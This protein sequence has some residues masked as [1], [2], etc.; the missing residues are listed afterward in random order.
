[1]IS[2]S[3]WL[4]WSR[5]NCMIYHVSLVGSRLCT[6]K[7]C[8]TLHNGSPRCGSVVFSD[9]QA[10]CVQRIA[11][12]GTLFRSSCSVCITL[13]YHSHKKRP[14]CLQFPETAFGLSRGGQSAYFLSV[15][16]RSTVS[17]WKSILHSSSNNST[18]STYGNEQWVCEAG[19][20]KVH[21]RVQYN[22]VACIVHRHVAQ[23]G[24]TRPGSVLCVHGRCKPRLPLGVALRPNPENNEVAACV[25]LLLSSCVVMLLS[26]YINTRYTVYD[27]SYHPPPGPILHARY[28][29]S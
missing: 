1:M 5:I 18:N 27:G 9:R 12:R 25:C 13:T 21:T 19:L 22:F 28:L 29:R 24:S 23:T 10:L 15:N 17:L 8:T 7:S 14:S 6:V 3:M 4:R 26:L 2:S 20:P 16:A 11:E